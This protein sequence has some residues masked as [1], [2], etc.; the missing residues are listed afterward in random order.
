MTKAAYRARKRSGQVRHLG[1]FDQCERCGKDYTVESGSQRFCPECQ[2]IHAAEYD[3]QTAILFYH[4][5]KDRLNPVRNERR[6][7]DPTRI[8]LVCGTEFNHGGTVSLTCSTKCR[9]DYYNQKHREKYWPNYKRKN[10]ERIRA[11]RRIR[12]RYVRV[13]RKALN[14]CPQC[15]KEW[16]APRNLIGF[17][18][19]YCRRCQDY[20]LR[21]SREKNLKNVLTP[22]YKGCMIKSTAGGTSRRVKGEVEDESNRQRQV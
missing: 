4:D 10:L 19:N 21:R 16:I 9:R 1:S 20:F 12:A 6:R 15:G 11:V 2:P 18:P 7:V 13:L 5:H 22:S 17:P 3:R 14:L 8:C